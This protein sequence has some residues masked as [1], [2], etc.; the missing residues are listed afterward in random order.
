MRVRRKQVSKDF[1]RSTKDHRSNHR[2]NVS[3]PRHSRSRSLKIK[4]FTLYIRHKYHL[5]AV[6]LVDT[7]FIACSARKIQILYYRAASRNLAGWFQQCGKFQTGKIIFPTWDRKEK[8][9][10][11]KKREG[12][13]AKR[14]WEVLSMIDSKIRVLPPNQLLITGI[15]I[16]IEKFLSPHAPAR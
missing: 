16:F 9:E 2:R 4:Q 3:N 7:L 13:A 5:R 6:C 15:C 8:I 12:V 11:K 14:R 10:R 1:E